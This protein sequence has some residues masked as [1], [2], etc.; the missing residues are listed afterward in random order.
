MLAKTAK[1]LTLWRMK[2]SV[3]FICTGNSCR[4]PMAEYLLKERLDGSGGWQSSSAGVASYPGM[5]ISSNAFKALKELGIDASSHRSRSL[6]Q[7]LIDEA[8]LIVV[9][10]HAH[11]NAV[12][13]IYPEATEKCRLMHSFGSEAQVRDVVDP[14]GGDSV[15]YRHTRDELD[16][17]IADLI[18]YLKENEGPEP[19]KD[20]P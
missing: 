7:Q 17:A 13:R 20:I 2:R 19:R 6:S 14:F 9:M 5:P 16:G 10:T 8:G 18:L 4:S 12:C 15:M 1:F 11:L 3:L